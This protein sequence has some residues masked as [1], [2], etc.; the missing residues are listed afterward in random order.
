MRPMTTK[1]FALLLDDA[2]YSVIEGLFGD[3]A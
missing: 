3:K 1:Q 2:E